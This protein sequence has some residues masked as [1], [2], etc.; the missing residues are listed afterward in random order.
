M[1]A[2]EIKSVDWPIVLCLFYRF[3]VFST[4][5]FRSVLVV[6]IL[7]TVWCV[8]LLLS[9]I[10]DVSKSVCVGCVCA[11]KQHQ[12]EKKLYC[13]ILRNGK[14]HS[15]TI[16]STLNQF[17]WQKATLGCFF[18]FFFSIFC[19]SSSKG[20]RGI[21]HYLFLFCRHSFRRHWSQWNATQKRWYGDETMRMKRS[22]KNNGTPKMEEWTARVLT[23][24]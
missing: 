18:F 7:N 23:G 17:K 4:Y 15:N 8:L 6:R 22:G 16:S 21:F 14:L 11:R 24:I 2:Q 5:S 12:R 20:I 13:T 9:N 1:L 10:S 3:Y 19:V